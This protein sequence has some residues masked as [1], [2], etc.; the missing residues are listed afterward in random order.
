MIKVALL[1]SGQIREIS[2]DFFSEG[3]KFFTEGVDYS[4]Y[5]QYWDETGQSMNHDLNK[6]KLIS[7]NAN[8]IF[9]KLFYD[10]P[11][12]N[13]I[14][15][16]FLEFQKKIPETHLKIHQENSWTLCK[17]SLP[18]IYSFCKLF[19]SFRNE[20]SDYDLIFKCRYDS[21]FT[22]RLLDSDLANFKL[23]NLYHINFSKAYYPK[24][25]YDIFFGGS[26][27][28]MDKMSKTWENIP[29]FVNHNFSNGLYKSDS[30]RLFYL[31]AYENQISVKSLSLRTCDI[32][33]Y[34][35]QKKYALNIAIS[36]I[37]KPSKDIL[38]MFKAWR[39]Y[40]FW[41]VKICKMNSIISIILI[42][43]DSLRLVR[44]DLF[45]LIYNIK[46]KLKNLLIKI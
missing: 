16:P 7:Q 12:L 23:N 34:K 14:S 28:V 46:N 21:V 38:K 27:Q 9:K 39:L 43:I 36:G 3:V 45:N 44:I 4:I 30:C 18:Q 29:Q 15:E 31:S 5:A 6:S 32:H 41:S 26:Y 17:N 2:S 42:L 24:R 19:D 11:L 20:L 13:S 22:H 25:I 10:L 35:Y 33:R 1:Y 37:A 40:Y 8:I